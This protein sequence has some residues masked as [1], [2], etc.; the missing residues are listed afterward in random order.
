MSKPFRTSGS[1][2]KQQARKS[3]MRAEIKYHVSMALLKKIDHDVG[4]SHNAEG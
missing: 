4:V 2:L 1:T 3:W